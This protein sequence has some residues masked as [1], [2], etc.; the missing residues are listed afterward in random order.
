[1]IQKAVSYESLPGQSQGSRSAHPL[2]RHYQEILT[3]LENV[4]SAG[5][6]CRC[7][8]FT[9][10]RPREGVSTLVANVAVAAVQ[11]RGHRAI[12][13]DANWRRPAL[14]ALLGTPPAPG[15]FELLTGACDAA[16]VLCSGP[17]EDLSV[18]LAGAPPRRW[19]P[20]EIA[21]SAIHAVIDDLRQHADWL[22]VDLPVAG[23]ELSHQVS[24]AL[25]GVVLL[26]QSERAPAAEISRIRQEYLSAGVPVLGS[27]FR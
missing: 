22:L 16:D 13:I 14:G 1:M 4:L 27:V 3:N 2:Q 24:I 12:A 23:D 5:S 8:G 17:V 10:C 26:V 18:V 25:D 11:L 20:G 7:V 9:S 19:S 6:A 21:P 15:W